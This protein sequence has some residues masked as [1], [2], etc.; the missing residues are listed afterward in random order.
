MLTGSAG[1]DWFFFELGED[2]ATDLKLELSENL[3]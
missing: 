1:N 2:T 3:G